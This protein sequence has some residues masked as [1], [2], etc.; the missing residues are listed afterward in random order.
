MTLST[1]EATAAW[2]ALEAT[3]STAQAATPP[4][5][6]N[7]RHYRPLV[8]AADAFVR[9]AQDQNRIYT[10]IPAFDNEMRGFGSGQLLVVTGYSH[11]GKTQLVMRTVRHNKGKRIAFF[12]PDEPATLILSKLASIESGVA[13]RELEER[14]SIGDAEAIR[15]LRDTALQDFP[16]LA[17]FDKPLLPN[18]MEE[19]I[20]EV[21]DV[22]GAPPDLVVVDY[23]ELVQAGETVQA[24]FDFLKGFGSRHE[25][26]L[27]AIHQTSRS[28]GA[29]GKKMTI[30]SGAYG[31]EQHATFLI[32]VW[33]RKNEIMAHLN[34]LRPKAQNGSESA[35]EKIAELEHDLRI[36]KYTVS[37]NLVKNK[38][39]GGMTLEDGIDLEID[40]ETGRLYDLPEGELPNQYLLELE[41]RRN[42]VK[43]TVTVPNQNFIQTSWDEG[44]GS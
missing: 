21:T 43:P 37:A 36:H 2:A 8:S 44:F 42:I 41:Q 29:D 22:W 1:Q 18:V 17:V 28:A 30:S 13:A 26:P 33:R 12:I 15:I 10:G 16:N 9:E 38:R 23:V 20:A 6:A 24:K 32:G 35:A 5:P 7:Y 39:P 4:P 25:V 34:E 11:S 3:A 14:V 31:G 19:G 40:V 27:L